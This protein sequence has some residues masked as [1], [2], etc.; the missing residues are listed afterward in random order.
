MSLLDIFFLNRGGRPSL[1]VFYG[2]R[3]I[4]FLF[5]HLRA[6]ARL[7]PA[8]THPSGSPA[9]AFP[10]LAPL[11][12]VGDARNVPDALFFFFPPACDYVPLRVHDSE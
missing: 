8:R 11:R 10:P 5:V 6:A 2:F 4:F 12:A 9:G 3:A 7:S 1:C